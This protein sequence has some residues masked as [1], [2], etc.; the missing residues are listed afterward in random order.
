M[1]PN[2]PDSLEAPAAL[3]WRR[4]NATRAGLIVDANAYFEAGR[5][6]MLKARRRIMLI[7]WDFDARIELTDKRLP[8]E[9]RTLGEFVLWLVARNPELE[10]FLL[11]WNIGA[12]RTLFRGTTIITLAR[13]MAHKRIHTRLDSA[14]TVGASHHHKIV[15]IDDCV[16]FC[17]GIDMTSNRWDTPAH[18]D[19]D[20]RRVA[21]DGSSYAP[22]HDAT[23]I[24][25]GPVAAALGELGR[26]RWQAAGGKALAPVSGGGDCWPEGVDAQFR[27]ISVAI[28][29][30]RPAVGREAPIREIEAT[31]LALIA[32]ARRHVYAES[33]Y[34][35][36]RRIAEAVAL[37]LDEPEGPEIV[38]VN[39]VTSHGWLE[40]IAMDTA[41]ARLYVA[42]RRL[43]RYGRFRIFHPHTKQGEP[44]YVHAKT[45]IVDD[46]VLHVGSSNMNNRSLRLDTECDVTID[47]RQPGNEGASPQI[48][49]LRDSLLAEHL[50]VEPGA[51]AAAID[52]KG[53]LIAAIE[54][55]RSAG[56]SLRPY[57]VPDLLDVEKW[58]ADHQ[59][60][61]PDGPE[62]IFEAT[63]GGRLLKRL[64][65]L[66]RRLRG[67][68][69]RASKK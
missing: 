36:S 22:W 40:P 58:L 10:V 47:S 52:D 62:E 50:G 20:P 15:V 57:E 63:T 33:Q 35:A 18:R 32:G 66:R 46:Q 12:L 26:Q 43:D 23:S 56:R 55:L 59:V 11:R 39:P 9:P 69:A 7:G 53:S 8:G 41:R 6:A 16:A 51:V 54:A 48:R 24:L 4:E 21:P 17:G 45:T 30:S 1:A 42:L 2:E 67:R 19:G 34:F 37:R 38:V 31:Y 5:A 14:S 25:E 68:G 44:I 60:L 29:R 61:D 64:N 28:C 49:A 65:R 13:W 3:C 27:D